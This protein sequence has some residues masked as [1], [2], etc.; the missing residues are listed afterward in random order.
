MLDHAEFVNKPVLVLQGDD[1]IIALPNGAKRL[2]THLKTKDKEL[3][4]FPGGDHWFYHALIP[5]AN[6]RYADEVRKTVS[7]AVID[8]LKVY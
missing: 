6:E 1:D 2:V 8:W 3:R 5:T 4:T 7:K